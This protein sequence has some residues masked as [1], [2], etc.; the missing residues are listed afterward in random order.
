[1][2]LQRLR[3][4]AEYLN[5][6]K[7]KAW[8][9]GHWDPNLKGL[10]LDPAGILDPTPGETKARVYVCPRC[11]KD[12]KSKKKYPEWAL[13]NFNWWGPRHEDWGKLTLTERRFLCPYRTIQTVFVL[14]PSNYKGPDG[15][16][17]MHCSGH[18]ITIPHDPGSELR[19]GLSKQAEFADLIK[20]LWVGK[21]KPPRSHPQLKKW[22]NFSLKKVR[23]I[24]EYIR[25]CN[26]LRS[27]EAPLDLSSF[28]ADGIP[29][30][31][32]D[33][34]ELLEDDALVMPSGAGMASVQGL[35][36]LR[37]FG[38][39]DMAGDREVSEQ[40][41]RSTAA[42]NLV[43]GGQSGGTLPTLEI[44]AP[45]AGDPVVEYKNELL[46][47]F[48]WLDWPDGIGAPFCE[49]RQRYGIPISLK[50][51]FQRALRNSDR[52]VRLNL[53]LLFFAENVLQR[54]EV[55]LHAKLVYNR[56][57]F[58]ADA[59][60][61][62][63]LG[64]GDLGPDQLKAVLKAIWAGS[65]EG[66]PPGLSV[67]VKHILGVGGKVTGSSLA[68]KSL[69]RKMFARTLFHGKFHIFQTISLADV[70][71]PFVSFFAG[72]DVDLDARTPVLPTS[73]R[74]REILA[75]DPVA[76]VQAYHTV[77]DTVEFALLGWNAKTMPGKAVEGGGIYGL[78][79]ALYYVDEAQQRGSLHRHLLLLLLNAPSPHKFWRRM[80]S[81]EAYMARVFAYLEPSSPRACPWVP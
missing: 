9:H 52:R 74:R 24:H 29:S 75:R 27:S 31:I 30:A 28:P 70:H 39:Y 81:S 10:M 14:R 41:L 47:Y 25:R 76:A 66:L 33:N 19:Q 71:L 15:N 5:V 20:V 18:A 23:K 77:M 56:P 36:D 38:L 45:L 26:R 63:R 67:L 78:L 21:E 43:E 42:T 46:W 58:A 48:G 53:P 35:H 50:S 17:Q 11:K 40:D 80:R 61:I 22:F 49:L 72:E 6:I 79:Q 16:L 7:E 2:C 59:A 44:E 34:I 37:S 4:S 32:Y 8:E 64:P 69:R 73:A 60:A 65:T 1:V 57:T 13:A 68:K 12:F 62:D 54:S 3:P 55:A 51:Y